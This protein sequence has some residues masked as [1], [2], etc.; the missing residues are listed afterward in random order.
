M[1]DPA[2]P[3]P[4]RTRLQVLFAANARRAVILR[5]GPRTHYCLIDWDLTT[6]TFTPGQWMKGLVR[7]SDLSPSGDKLIYWAAQHHESAP[8][9]RRAMPGLGTF[10]P[11]TQRPLA[12][13]K[14]RKRR[15]VPRYLGGPGAVEARRRAREV[16]GTWTAI[17]SPPYFSA[18]AIWPAHGHWTGG[19]VFRSE[20][21][22]YLYEREDAMT[23][24]V[25]APL[26]GTISF[27]SAA[28]A[29]AH[30]FQYAPSAAR[31][32]FGM[33][34]HWDDRNEACD[35]VEKERLRAA[36]AEQGLVRLDW[37]HIAG[38]RM[39]FAG[40]GCIYRLDDWRGTKG[41]HYLSAARMIV[42][43]RDMTFQLVTP[44]PASLKW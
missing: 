16:T 27:R 1:P 20:H 21:D 2:G 41:S 17:S 42:D 36:F 7:L 22:V 28:Q 29:A 26:S 32:T 24:I 6:D 35:V 4:Y 12:P 40:D 25:N 34:G 23:P 9:R 38:S 18:L 3:P 31:P 44:P 8:W 13:L 11:I 33:L 39:I 19:G 14:L 43:F 30:G 37:V 15:K 10:D 5:R